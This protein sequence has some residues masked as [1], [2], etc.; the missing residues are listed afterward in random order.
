MNDNFLEANKSQKAST[1]WKYIVD[2]GYFLNN[3]LCWNL[4][5]NNKTNFWHNMWVKESTFIEKITRPLD[6][7]SQ[8]TLA[9]AIS[10]TITE[11]GISLN[12]LVL[13]KYIVAKI[14]NI[15][16]SVNDIHDII[17]GKFIFNR[18]LY[19]KTTTWANYHSIPTYLYAKLLNHICK[20]NLIPIIKCFAWKS[21]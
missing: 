13:P 15:P 7:E 2:H 21:Y 1:I 12:W 5:N 9:L 18:K 16:I 17:I 8:R 14:M 11:H 19:V 6:L 3:G 10:S 20:L 4:G